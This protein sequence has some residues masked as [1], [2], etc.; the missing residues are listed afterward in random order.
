M[1]MRFIIL[2][3]VLRCEPVFALSWRVLTEVAGS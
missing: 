2:Q 3:C 1:N